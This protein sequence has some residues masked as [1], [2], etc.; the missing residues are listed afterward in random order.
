[1]SLLSPGA[2]ILIASAIMVLEKAKEEKEFYDEIRAAYLFPDIPKMASLR[3]RKM[4]EMKKMA[5]ILA[6]DHVYGREMQ[7][8]A[9]VPPWLKSTG[10]FFK[11]IPGHIADKPWLAPVIG[12][13]LGAGAGALI[14]DE[15]RLRGAGIGLGAGALAGFGAHKYLNLKGQNTDLLHRKGLLEKSR[16]WQRDKKIGFRNELA[17]S[18][19][20]HEGIVAGLQDRL[21][22]LKR[23]LANARSKGTRAGKAYMNTI[24]EYED[25]LLANGYSPDWIN[26]NV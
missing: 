11:N 19:T 20:E 21:S 17:S 8:T 2:G 22:V 14:D 26:A 16:D 5:M 9:G 18:K 4:N 1:M 24:E 12:G 6:A 3:R 25:E 23:N 7:K 13:G 10:S 15:N